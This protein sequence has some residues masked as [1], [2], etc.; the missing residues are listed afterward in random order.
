MSHEV[1]RRVITRAQP[2]IFPDRYRA[3]IASAVHLAREAAAAPS[4]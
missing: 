1:A 2:R 4:D 3:L